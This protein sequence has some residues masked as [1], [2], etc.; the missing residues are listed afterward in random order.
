MLALLRTDEVLDEWGPDPLEPVPLE[1]DPL[2]EFLGDV[3]NVEIFFRD[4]GFASDDSLFSHN[5]FFQYEAPEPPL[6]TDPLED[7]SLVSQWVDMDLVDQVDLVDHME[8]FD[9]TTRWPDDCQLPSL[10]QDLAGTHNTAL[11][12]PPPPLGME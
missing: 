8:I 12:P 1:R 3:I 7:N 10:P 5:P 2:D 9:E 11:L 4:D 6:R